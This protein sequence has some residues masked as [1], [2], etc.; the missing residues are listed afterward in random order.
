VGNI[1]DY[2]DSVKYYVTSLKDL[3]LI[4]EHFDKYPLI[5]QK[6][7][8]YLLFKQA[9]ELI[10][11]KE[12]LTKEGFNQLLAIKASSNK[13]FSDELK[14]AFPNV[15]PV[16]RPLIV[17][18]IIQNPNWLAGFVA[19]EG[20]FCVSIFKDTTNNGFTVKLIFIMAQ[21]SRDAALMK[22]LVD[23]LGCGR[24]TPRLNQDAGDFI[25]TKFSDFADRV[26]GKKKPKVSIYNFVSRSNNVYII[27]QYI[28]YCYLINNW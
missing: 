26:Y 13:G 1:S 24:Y 3:A 19:G 7:A 11:R 12:H 28:H 22:S 4:I 14:K 25:V 8:D 15:I 5:T 21:H 20:C 6:Q 18:Q 17:N 10:N 2:K 9:F 16:Q 23:Y 27:L